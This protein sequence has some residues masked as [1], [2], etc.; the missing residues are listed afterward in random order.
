MTWGKLLCCL[1]VA[2][3]LPVLAGG[4]LKAEVVHRVPEPIEININVKLQVEQ[5]LD[6]VFSE[7][8]SQDGTLDY[9]KRDASDGA[10]EAGTE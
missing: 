1:S 6:S 3:L 7:L 8:D 2:A 5:R 9:E 10:G 4:C